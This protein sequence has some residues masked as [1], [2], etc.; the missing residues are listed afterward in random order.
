MN[1]TPE[2]SRRLKVLSD[3]SS[4]SAEAIVNQLLDTYLSQVVDD[5]DTNLLEFLL[6]PLRFGTAEEARTV[7]SRYNAFADAQPHC[8]SVARPMRE[9]TGEWRIAFREQNC[10]GAVF[11]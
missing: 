2:N 11:E 9:P 1:L 6:R 5:R 7:I 8:S 3:I 10:D 4:T